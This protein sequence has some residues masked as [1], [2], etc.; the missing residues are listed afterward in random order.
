MK[1]LSIKKAALLILFAGIVLLMV[2]NFSSI[3]GTFG[4]VGKILAPFFA[5]IVLAFVLNMIMVPIDAFLK[6]RIFKKKPGIAKGLAIVFSYIV[7]IAVVVALLAFVIPELVNSITGFVN[8][9]DSYAEKLKVFAYNLSL[10]YDL[11]NIDINKFVDSFSENIEKIANDILLAIGNMVPHIFAF[12]SNIVNF[13]F[14]FVMAVVISANILAYKERL[15]RQISRTTKAYLPKVYPK[16]AKLSVITADTFKKYVS[17]QCIEAIILGMLCYIG[18]VIFRFDYAI[19]IS[20][21]IAVT[22][23]IPVAGAY[24]GGGIAVVLLAII[25]PIKALM[26]L[27]YLVCLQQF[28][29]NLIYPKVVGT[30]LE[31]PGIWVIFAVTF[32]GGALGIVGILFAV[33]IMSVIYKLLRESVAEREELAKKTQ[34]ADTPV[35]KE[36]IMAVIEAIDKEDE[37]DDIPEKGTGDVLGK[38]VVVAKQGTQKQKKNN[39]QKK[40]KK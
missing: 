21:V 39:N 13:L 40:K 32:G 27:V 6:K 25:S 23:L 16:L 2:L 37:A 35:K 20:T 18:M 3:I 36:G 17:G 11:E 24:I 26:F 19:L 34:D 31:L 12:M 14:N 10:Q 28:E 22:A 29:T 38:E 4:V 30:S 5:G 1:R 15:I 9:W 8:N 7:L 33:P